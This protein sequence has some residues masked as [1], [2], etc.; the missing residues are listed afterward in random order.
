MNN[1][2]GETIAMMVVMVVVMT[3]VLTEI[4]VVK[5]MSRQSIEGYKGQAT[6]KTNSVGEV[7]ID[8]LTWGKK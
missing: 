5:R 1:K 7:T 3:V 6:Y 4:A 8:K 2:T